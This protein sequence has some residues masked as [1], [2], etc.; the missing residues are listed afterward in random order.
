MRSAERD[1]CGCP[2]QVI[3]CAHWE[4]WILWLSPNGTHSYSGAHSGPI[5]GR[6]TVWAGRVPLEP[7]PCNVPGHLALSIEGEGFDTDDLP[8][9]DAEFDRREAELLEPSLA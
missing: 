6:Y 7:L 9:A 8:A 2:A 4:G 5:Y 3:R 1:G